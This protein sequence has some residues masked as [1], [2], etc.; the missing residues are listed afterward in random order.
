MLLN[1]SKTDAIKLIAE[2][3]ESKLKPSLAYGC[4]GLTSFKKIENM[5]N[6]E[7]I[8]QSILAIG[9][10]DTD[11]N[12]LQCLSEYRVIGASSDHLIMDSGNNPIK[13]GT[14]VFFKVN[15]SALLRAM[16]SS[17]VT[18]VII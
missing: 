13:I 3:I 14:E 11:P 10:Q 1:L 6:E 12:G 7:N 17:F 5:S 2:V 4:A 15:Y 18:K 9:H 8:Y 16:M